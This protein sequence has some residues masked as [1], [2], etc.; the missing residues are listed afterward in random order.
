MLLYLLPRAFTTQGFVV[1]GAGQELFS[2]TKE[3][4]WFSLC[5]RFNQERFTGLRCFFWS[6]FEREIAIALLEHLVEV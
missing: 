3:I 1:N 4:H 6:K 5:L 2:E